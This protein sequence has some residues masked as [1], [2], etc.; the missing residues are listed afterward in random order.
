MLLYCVILFIIIRKNEKRFVL[1]QKRC[2]FV[3]RI[4]RKDTI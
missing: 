2:I 4:E 3:T 1:S